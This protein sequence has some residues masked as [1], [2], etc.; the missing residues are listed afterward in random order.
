MKKILIIEDE[1]TVR[2]GIA[3]L[4]KEEGYKIFEAENGRAGVDTAKKILPDLIIS[5]IL[6]PEMNGY[7]VLDEMQ[8]DKN[9][10]SIPFIFL[11]AKTE[12]SDIRTGM[13]I[14]A[15][16]Y[17]TK[18]YKADDLLCAVNSR[19]K[20]SENLE[21]KFDTI[22][23]NIIRSIPHELR[24]PLVSIIGFSQ[25]IKDSFESLK[26]EEIVDMNEKIN[27][28]GFEL[29]KKIQK[30]L[31]FSELEF[32]SVEKNYPNENENWVKNSAEIIKTAAE[33]IAKTY[34]RNSD[35]NVELSESPLN[36]S[37]EHL[38]NIIEEIV[39][40]SFKFSEKGTAVAVKSFADENS[41]YIEITDNGVGMTNDQI[42]NVGV[43]RQFDKDVHF[44][45]GLGFGLTI[46]KKIVDLYQ[47]SFFVESEVE[48]YTKVT[49]I[50][51]VK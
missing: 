17:L 3:D 40:N 21:E 29:L 42:K 43:L 20:K 37:E 23:Q 35:L 15:D 32:L 33:S 38:K 31:S 39:D 45:N 4:L 1:A 47:G 13:N 26:P 49:L 24:T 2:A 28:S 48:N 5:D 50:F 22:Y 12:K 9:T 16:D 51:A 19:L 14:G 25:L 36:I 10:S 18:P 46:A 34:G 8:S 6:M 11:S 44:Q 41:F 27:T 7:E 30:F